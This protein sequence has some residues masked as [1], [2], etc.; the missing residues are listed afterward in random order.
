MKDITIKE[1]RSRRDLKTFIFLPEK[2]HKDNPNWIPPL[3][4]DEWGLFNPKKN[5]LFSYCD[6]IQ[7]LAYEGSKPVGRIMG[8]INKKYNEMKSENT[9]RFCF[10]ECYDDK[11]ISHTLLSAV[12]DWAQKLGMNKIIGPYAFSDKDPQGCQISGFDKPG[13]L[14]APNN[15]SFLPALIENEGYSKEVDLVEYITDIPSKLPDLFLKIIERASRM[16]KIE[17]IEFKTKKAIKPYILDVLELMNDTFSS[18]YGFVPLSDRE[19]QDFARRYLPILDPAFIKAAKIGDELVGFVIAMPNLSQ[20]ILKARGRLWPFGFIHI[21]GSIKKSTELL[22]L[23][24]GVKQKY[25]GRGIDAIMGA[26]I[27]QSASN[28]RMLTLDSHLVLETNKSMRAD[29]DR[30]GARISKTFRIYQKQ[31]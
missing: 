15:G 7:L 11:E 2:I 29:Y 9:G 24:G 13:V 12:E 6:Y 18:I 26:K 5:I 16:E 31:L 23:L 22:M 10:L 28:S 17:I 8:L 27:L 25:R 21:L 1:L 30:L 20:G 4:S 3:Y 14:A 19:K